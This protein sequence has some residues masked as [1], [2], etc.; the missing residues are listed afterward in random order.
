MHILALMVSSMKEG[1]VFHI[2][3]LDG[4][5]FALWKEQIHDILVQKKQRAPISFATRQAALTEHFQV[6]QYEW[7]ELDALAR[8]TIYLHLAESVYFTV[9]D[10]P[11]SHAT[12]VK[13]CNTYEQNT[14]E[15]NTPSNKVF[16]MRRL[17]NL[18]M[19]ENGSVA[20]HINDFES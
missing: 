12:W 20:H 2:K 6:T 5:N 10:C 9:L 18:R 7:E 19:K 8:S 3:N 17:F 16:L 13:L 11:T 15:Q 1:N 4:S 14:Y